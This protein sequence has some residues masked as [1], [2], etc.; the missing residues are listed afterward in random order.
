MKK[1][2]LLLMYMLVS[3]VWVYAQTKIVTGKVQDENGALLGNVSVQVKGTK[4]GTV[5]SV[6]GTFS[7]SV[8]ATAKTLVFSIIEL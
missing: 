2:T 5:S 3:V 7:L 4:L 6:D 8:P 1:K